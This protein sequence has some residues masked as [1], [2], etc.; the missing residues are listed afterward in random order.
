MQIERW[1]ESAPV[2]ADGVLVRRFGGL[3]QQS[4]VSDLAAAA[5]AA[6]GDDRATR[7][8]RTH[9]ACHGCLVPRRHAAA[10]SPGAAGA[11]ASARAV[12]PAAT[13]SGGPDSG[14]R[15]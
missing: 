12:R 7:P 11:A 1:V 4:G 5:I 9:G 6:S 3:R 14:V 8:R 13:G 2:A 15:T 10:S